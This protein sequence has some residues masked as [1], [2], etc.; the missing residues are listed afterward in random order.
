M[1]G[2]QKQKAISSVLTAI[3]TGILVW[4]TW[5]YVQLTQRLAEA[6]STQLQ[7]QEE[8]ELA[9]WRELQS[10]I[11]LITVIL[12][13]L[14]TEQQSADKRMR[15]A[16]SWDTGDLTRFQALA[17]T[18]GEAVGQDAALAVGAMIWMRERVK[19]VKGVRPEI[20]YDWTKF[21]WER[22]VAELN[23]AKG[24]IGDVFEAL[25]P[26]LA[27]IRRPNQG[28]QPDAQEDALG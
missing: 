10:Q 1:Y 17:S 4:I 9:K 22:W 2:S 21:P 19:E 6:A 25:K 24:K 7:F 18:L 27:A 28:M 23:Q 5:R 11:K 14:P 13:S 26:K 15:S 8:A 20:G 3:V 16:I 12:A